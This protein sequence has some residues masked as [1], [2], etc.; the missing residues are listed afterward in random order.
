[1]LKCVEKQKPDSVHVKVDSDVLYD[2]AVACSNDTGHALR[3]RSLAFLA[4]STASPFSRT[5]TLPQPAS[6]AWPALSIRERCRFQDSIFLRTG[7]V[8]EP[9]SLRCRLHLSV[10]IVASHLFRNDSSSSKTKKHSSRTGRWGFVHG[11]ILW[12]TPVA[13]CNSFTI[14]CVW[15]KNSKFVRSRGL[16]LYLA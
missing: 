14:T 15:L 4:K 9:V 5:K 6:I 3:P 2:G 1:M 8:G 16:G 7:E 10:A 12:K 11:Q 13:G